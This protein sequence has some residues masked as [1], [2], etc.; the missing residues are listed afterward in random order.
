MIDLK[1]KNTY[2][3][4]R[5]SMIESSFFITDNFD[6][7]IVDKDMIIEDCQVDPDS[8]GGLIISGKARHYEYIKHYLRDG[9]RKY[10]IFDLE[11]IVRNNPDL[12]DDVEIHDHVV[13]AREK[14]Y[15]FW[16][17]KEEKK[18]KIFNAGWVLL[19]KRKEVKIHLNSQGRIVAY[20]GF[21]PRAFSEE[22]NYFFSKYFF[23]S[24]E[25]KE[26]ERPEYK[27]PK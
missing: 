11:F 23:T 13:K 18:Y 16:L 1:V 9:L 21:E 14:W 22:N 8:H 2:K 27:Y 3:K 15:Q 4:I 5:V 6:G 10:D 7:F 19:K 26:P 20:E 24:P 25:Y 12:I 17:P